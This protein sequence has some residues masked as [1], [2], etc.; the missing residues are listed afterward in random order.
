MSCDESTNFKDIFSIIWTN[1]QRLRFQGVS[2]HSVPLALKMALLIN[3]FPDI[4]TTLMTIL[5]GS[6]GLLAIYIINFYIKV[7]MY[8]KGPIPIPLIGNLLRE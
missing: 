2:S 3:L 1:I 4:P 7:S 6:L 8:P 5:Y